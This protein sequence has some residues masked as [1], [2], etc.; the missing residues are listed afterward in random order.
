MMIGDVNV[1]AAGIRSRMIDTASAHWNTFV[2]EVGA[3]QHLYVE[4]EVE[5]VL[6]DMIPSLSV[7]LMDSLIEV[8][9]NTPEMYHIREEMTQIIRDNAADFVRWE[10]MVRAYGE[11][12]ARLREIGMTQADFV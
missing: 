1:T 4:E 10:A 8:F 9:A 2:D 3:V 7:E 6:R 11:A 5:H 12:G